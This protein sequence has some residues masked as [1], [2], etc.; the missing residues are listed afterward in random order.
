MSIL[1]V[2]AHLLRSRVRL[3]Q[4]ILLP[5][6][7]VAGFLG[8][9]LCSLS[10]RYPGFLPFSESEPGVSSIASYP[11]INIATRCGWTRMIQSAQ[12]LPESV[13]RGFTSQDKRRSIGE[14]TV[15]PIALD[16]LAW[17]VALVLAAF[18]IAF[19]VGRG[20]KAVFPGDYSVPLF[21]LSMLAGACI[22]RSLDMVQLGQYVDKRVMDRIGSSVSDFLIGF[23]VA[24][25]KVGVVVE[26]AIP[27][28]VLSL[29][30]IAF[31]AAVF[32]FV[33]RRI[34]HNFWF[35]RSIFVYGWNT[36]VVAIGITLLRVV[37]PRLKTKTLEDFGLAYV[38]FA[39]IN[40]AVLTV[41]PPLVANGVIVGPALALIAG[42]FACLFASRCLVGW[43][44]QPANAF[45]EGEA[46]TIADQ[47]LGDVLP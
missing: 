7:I 17:H 21:P 27:I 43:F 20:I 10:K 29:F 24:S 15:S 30:G 12:E 8:L 45:R 35:E 2:A 1:L 6:P 39:V 14:E 5:T 18:A 9:L 32:W 36:G 25:I 13:R 40:V 34:Y 23:G 46:E 41:L 42:F 33:G 38:F 37:D 26:F 11:L 44:R 19:F 16:P 31:A 22:Q 4:H 3:F 28:V 47:D